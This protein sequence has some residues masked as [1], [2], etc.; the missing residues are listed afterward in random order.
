LDDNERRR[1]LDGVR[2]AF[3]SEIGASIAYTVVP[4]NV[5]AE[6]TVVAAMAAG[7]REQRADGSTCRPIRL[8]ATKGGQTTIGTLTFCQ[9]PGSSELKPAASS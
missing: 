3:V 4:K 5:D 2:Q 7:P 6:P 9:K 8:S 1:L